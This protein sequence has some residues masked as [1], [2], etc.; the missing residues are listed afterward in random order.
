MRH[1]L[2]LDVPTEAVV[3]TGIFVPST[4]PSSAA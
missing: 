2:G 3:N 1:L 4:L